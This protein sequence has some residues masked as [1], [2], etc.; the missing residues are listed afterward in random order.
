MHLSIFRA[1]FGTQLALLIN[2]T[3]AG[4]TPSLPR[5]S[6]NGS[7]A[8]N[9][10]LISW[11]PPTVIVATVLV[12]GVIVSYLIELK[13]TLYRPLGD[14]TDDITVGLGTTATNHRAQDTLTTDDRTLVDPRLRANFED[15]Y[16][17]IM[18]NVQRTGPETGR[19]TNG[20]VSGDP[21]VCRTSAPDTVQSSDRVVF[22]FIHV[23]AFCRAGKS[24]RYGAAFTNCGRLPLSWC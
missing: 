23:S 18:P 9:R 21:G 13:Q 2:N 8:M 24:P 16:V 11:P 7:A 20:V 1:V 12:A 4:T 19:V 14:R 6:V 15:R 17:F 22:T 3:H 10:F 5:S